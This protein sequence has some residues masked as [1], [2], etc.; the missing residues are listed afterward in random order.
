VE[1][2][3]KTADALIDELLTT[4]F[5]LLNIKFPDVVSIAL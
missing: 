2:A 3:C 4:Q 1:S 5:A